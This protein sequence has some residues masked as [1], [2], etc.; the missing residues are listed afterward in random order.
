MAWIRWNWKKTCILGYSNC[1]LGQLFIE[2]WGY[3]FSIALVFSGDISACKN[4]QNLDCITHLEVSTKANL[5]T[6]KLLLRIAPLRIQ[7]W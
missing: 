2:F 7:K 3:F 1:A 5:Q 4:K 6:W